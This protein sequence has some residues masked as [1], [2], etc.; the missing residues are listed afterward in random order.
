MKNYKEPILIFNLFTEDVVCGSGP[1]DPETP[2][3][4][5]GNGLPWVDVI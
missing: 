4:P 1:S 5:G 3:V 2:E